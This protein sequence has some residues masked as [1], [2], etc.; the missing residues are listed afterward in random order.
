MLHPGEPL[1]QIM[2][3]SVAVYAAVLI[4][5]RVMGKRQLGQMNVGDLVVILLI[6]NA[7]QNAM[8]GSDVSLTGGVVAAITLLIVN[9]SLTQ[10]LERNPFAERVIEGTPTLLIKD[11]AFVV[12]NLRREGLVREEVES[13]IREHGVADEHAVRVAYLE[14][15][16]TVSVIPM[17]APVLKGGRKVRRVRQFRRH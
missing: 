7:V 2:V 16:G 17:E 5:L 1:W 6:A 9:F 8:V 3:R 11:G 4:G 10:L 14:P 15:D 12:P 13:A